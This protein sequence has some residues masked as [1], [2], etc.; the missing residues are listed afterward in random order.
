MA[1]AATD[2]LA[3]IRFGC[4]DATKYAGGLDVDGLT[5]LPVRSL[6]LRSRL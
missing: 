3:D 6:P 1:R 2:L 4:A 5:R